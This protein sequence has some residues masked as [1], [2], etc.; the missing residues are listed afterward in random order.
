MFL[1]IRNY[2]AIIHLKNAIHLINMFIII[3]IIII[4]VHL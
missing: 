1:L 3:I 2:L 4:K